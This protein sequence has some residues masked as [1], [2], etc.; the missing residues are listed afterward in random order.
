MSLH[1]IERNAEPL[2]D[3]AG[4]EQTFGVAWK[5][6][7]RCRRPR[8]TY[9]Y[10]SREGSTRAMPRKAG[11]P[12]RSTGLDP[13][14]AREADSGHIRISSNGLACGGTTKARQNYFRRGREM[15]ARKVEAAI[16][17]G[18]GATIQ[19]G[20]RHCKSVVVRPDWGAQKSLGFC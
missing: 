2:G 19:S 12:K 1:P 15:L 9:A 5:L 13:G 4:I 8:L 16:L 3:F 10:S 14:L 17:P 11:E 20:A 18:I 7:G 6:E